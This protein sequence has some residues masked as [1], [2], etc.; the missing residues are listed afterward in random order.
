MSSSGQI[1]GAVVGGVAGFFLGPAGSF[2]GVALGAQLGMMA[3]G[4]LDPPKGPTVTGPRLSDLTIQTSTYG[5][6][7]PRIYGTVALHG[8]VFW[9]ENNKILEILVKKKSGGK[10]GSKTV[11]KTYY[12]YA[13][14]ALG[15]CRG[16]IAGVKRIWISGHLYYDAGSSDAGTIKASNDAAT[17]F[18]VHL[19]TDTQLPNSRMQATLGV[20]NTPAY[21]GLAYIVFYDL[22]LA[23]YGEALAAAQVKVEVMQAATYADEVTIR[24]V[25]DHEWVGLDY[26]NGMLWS[27]G[28]LGWAGMAYP[29]I[30]PTLIYS[31]D[32][33][34]TW[35]SSTVLGDYE[36]DWIGLAST[37]DRY[38]AIAGYGDGKVASSVD[39]VNWTITDGP[40]GKWWMNVIVNDDTFLLFGKDKSVDQYYCYTTKDGISF[41]SFPFTPYSASFYTWAHGTHNG[42][43]YA[44]AAS[45]YRSHIVM[46]IGNDSGDWVATVVPDFDQIFGICTGKDNALVA[47]GKVSTIDPKT[48]TTT[49]IDNGIT[50]GPP[51]V[52]TG[53]NWDIR[54]IYHGTVLCTCVWK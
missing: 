2:A 29:P 46:T 44:I 4:L 39:L 12:N 13:T 33:G 50:W 9:L 36:G 21:R 24:G 18:T 8:N 17:G 28:G 48:Y 54:N 38:L 19:G 7:I 40:V 11:T 16:P 1:V 6:V 14:F 51:V 43:V 20:D 30:K 41:S 49:S 32:M 42:S 25:P 47:V 3:G 34:V 52:I 37:K 31:D 35:T 53:T 5:A 45:N 22:P 15:L 27:V 23:D 10:G 26:R